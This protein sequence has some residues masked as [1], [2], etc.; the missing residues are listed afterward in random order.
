MAV[1]R[2]W[3][4]AGSPRTLPRAVLALVH[5][6]VSRRVR[7]LLGDDAWG[8]LVLAVARAAH[9]PP[10]APTAPRPVGPEEAVV[11]H[12]DL[13]ILD[14]AVPDP[15]VPASQP[16]AHVESGRSAD[17]ADVRAATA[18]LAMLA[19][20]VTGTLPATDVA[21]TGRRAAAGS[22]E[23]ELALVS[24][25]AGLVLLH[26]RLIEHVRT[27]VD[28]HPGLDPTRVRAQALACL[29]DPDDPSLALDPLVA[30]LAGAGPGWLN[31]PP[32]P[33]PR[34]DEVLASAERALTWFASLLP[35]FGGST[36]TFVRQGWVLR[37]G[38]VE[39]GL[40]PV[41]L[42]AAT[43]PLDVVLVRLPY[44]VSLLK[45]PWSP[46]VTVRFRP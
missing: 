45:L 23:V 4:A 35:G 26:P 41:R 9:R 1:A 27:A 7:V 28:L 24:R 21:A 11:A 43:H 20:V 10:P 39:H 30:V 25:A 8:R 44:P 42:T 17:P 12:E 22:D 5:P 37:T 29:A 14:E 36:P 32:T 19:D 34:S 33:L 13:P 3:L 16:A 31:E 38:V 6:D 15:A 40:D 2:A 46:P 18:A